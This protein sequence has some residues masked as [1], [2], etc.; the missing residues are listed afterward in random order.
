MKAVKGI[1]VAAVALS[2]AGVASASSIGVKA[3]YPKVDT[4]DD[5][6]LHL[7]ITGSISLSDSLWMSGMFLGGTFTDVGD[8]PGNDVDTADAEIVLGYT[9]NIVDVGLG[10]RYT[11]WAD[12]DDADDDF[13][14]FGPM[15]YVGL[16]NT[17]GDAPIGWY[18]GGS[19][20]F[21]DF[22]DAYDDDWDV[23]YEH[24]NIEGGL[25]M[26]NGSLSATLGYRVKEFV[27]SAIDISFK[28]VAG[29][30]GFGF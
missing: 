26:A 22:G 12:A 4:A 16:G 30:V 1:V 25:F 28:G 14:I 11:K 8:L 24:Y 5:P 19:Y 29:S 21:K 6:A 2:I 7:G 27:D 10:G 18:C 23:T 9:A 13:Q 20:M 15:V 3:W 17:F